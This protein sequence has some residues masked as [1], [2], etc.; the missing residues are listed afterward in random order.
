MKTSANLENNIIF[1]NDLKTHPIIVFYPDVSFDHV[2]TDSSDT[3]AGIY[4]LLRE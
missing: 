4:S 3:A 1:L 2:I